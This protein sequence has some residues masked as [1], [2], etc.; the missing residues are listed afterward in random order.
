MI[1]PARRMWVVEVGGKRGRI[2][3]AMGERSIADFVMIKPAIHVIAVSEID[4]VFAVI[5][6]MPE[7]AILPLLATPTRLSTI[8]DKFE[9]NFG[10]ME[11]TFAFTTP[12]QSKFTNAF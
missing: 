11:R 4:R 1:V 2:W 6:W 7:G 10:V 5:G 12:A 3:W 9:T 8:S